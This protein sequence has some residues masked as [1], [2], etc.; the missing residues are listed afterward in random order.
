M[1]TVAVAYTV[2]HQVELDVVIDY[3]CCFTSVN[4]PL[5]MDGSHERHE[6]LPQEMM[7]Y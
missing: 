6:G 7:L 5:I 3:I 1:S 2:L 4:L